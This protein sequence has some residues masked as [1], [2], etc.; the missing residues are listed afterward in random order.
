M[1][2]ERGIR[3]VLLLATIL[4][5]TALVVSGTTIAVLYR[6]GFAQ[7]RERLTEHAHGLA[8][9]FEAVSRFDAEFIAEDHPG[10]AKQATLDQIREAH[11]M[12]ERGPDTSQLVIGERVGEEIVFLL[13][14]GHE[15]PA[16]VA[17]DG[18][19]AAPM[20]AAL[21][22]GSGSM[23]GLDFRGERV[24]AAYE[25]VPGL[26]VGVVTKIS[27][28]EIRAPFL[29]ASGL[30]VAITIG[31][32]ILG[33]FSFFRLSNPL[34]RRIEESE[35]L[36]ATLFGESKDAHLLTVGGRVAECNEGSCEL[37]GLTRASLL[38]RRLVELSPPRQAGGEDSKERLRQVTAEAR[39]GQTGVFS[40]LFQRADGSAVETEVSLVEV[41]V[42]GE[43][44][45]LATAR[46]VT[47]RN[48]QLEEIRLLAT[49]VEQATEGI[50]VTDP[51]GV[52]QYVNP[53]F[54]ADCGYSRE[55]LLGR[56]PSLLK[57]G[58]H[59]DEFYQELWR[60]ILG[61][62]SW[63]GVLINRRK[64]GELFR[65]ETVISPIKGER[66]EITNFIAVKRDITREVA[67][68]EELRHA[69]RLDAIGRLA[70]GIAHDF[71]NQLTAILG[72]AEIAEARV[73]ADP[74]AA[75]A[76]EQVV[77]A[78]EKASALTRQLL[79]FGRRQVLEPKVIDPNQIIT[80]SREM[81]TRLIG[82]DVDLVYHLAEDCGWVK[83]DPG[84]LEQVV[85]N[86]AVNGRDAM[87][88][89]GALT[90]ETAR[91]D[92]DRSYL[93]RHPSAS[94]G[95]H[96]MI[97]VSDAGEGMD[98]ETLDKVFDPFFTTKAVGRGTGL[99]LS[100]VHG[101]VTQSGGY[102][103]VYS[104]PGEGTT[105]K[106]YLPR[107]GAGEELDLLERPEFDGPDCSGNERILVVEDAGPVR[108]MVE[109][110]LVPLGYQVLLAA[111]GGEAIELIASLERSVDLL[112]T[113][114]V[115]PRASGVEV[116]EALLARWAG[117]PV[118]FMSG[119]TENSIV[120]HGVLDAGRTY[121]PKP[122]TPS[123]L[124]RKIREV[125]DQGRA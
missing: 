42:G 15:V 56:K 113:D 37:L 18:E 13:A 55:E 4:A 88:R 50:C 101:I 109:K 20:R 46:D 84:Q 49:A 5:V 9:V 67:L 98:P 24:L 75:D 85:V 68:E 32:A 96:V 35:S 17:F 125:L 76:L 91:V 72:F 43:A 102:I 112:L 10:G 121:L 103:W 22:G 106:I 62:E 31:L 119:Y 83:V 40:W 29:F 16:P 54:I 100:T 95:P 59:E 60:V 23:V 82:E 52:L 64:N 66:G 86:L 41:Q 108:E 110:T 118:I 117:T 94:P 73:Q 21:S 77:R 2:P 111:D 51:E 38:G 53:C 87:P 116:A 81:L 47:E 57:S 33:V 1:A 114:V 80:Q 97:A 70:G 11:R 93:E 25:P 6:T 99:G 48:R 124:A 27:L 71:N 36:Y 58:L 90:I 105:F 7:V 26:G 30:A 28:A 74:A 104:E 79:A 19:L 34:L 3:R 78:G 122:V 63:T 107:A 61:G 115:M 120:H 44:G 39:R 14:Y 65:E 89:G 8:L 45:Y 92:F 69:Q 12:L 123:L